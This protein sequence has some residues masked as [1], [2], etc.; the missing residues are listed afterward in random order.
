MLRNKS[1]LG[2]AA[3]CCLFAAAPVHAYVDLAPT[4]ARI[5]R[6]S[7]TITVAEIDVA[8]NPDER[9]R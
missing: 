6:E 8:F 9:E 7:Q 3:L 1:W 5:V 4:I 2:I